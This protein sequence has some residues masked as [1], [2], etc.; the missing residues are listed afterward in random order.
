MLSRLVAS[1]VAP[2]IPTCP[3]DR[4]ACGMP[5]AVTLLAKVT[6]GEL[7]TSVP[8]APA[9]DEPRLIAVVDPETPAVPISTVLVTPD[10]VAPLPS[11]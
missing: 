8:P 6:V 5:T 4:L 7:T 1:A 2:P 11:E 10:P 3:T 9:T